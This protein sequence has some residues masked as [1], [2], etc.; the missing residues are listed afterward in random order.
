[1]LPWA[2]KPWRNAGCGA[3]RKYTATVRA[4][5]L[6][7]GLMRTTVAAS[8]VSRPSTRKVA[9]APTRTAT[10][11]C[12]ASAASSSSCE[13]STTSRIR[14]STATRSPGWLSR[15]AI[16]PSSGATRR[17]SF[18]D[19]R[20]RSAAA[21]A[22][23]RLARAPSA[24]DCAVSSAVGEMK[25]WPTSALLLASVRSATSS[26]AR[27]ERV[28]CSACCSR[29]WYSLVSICPSTCPARTLS[30]SRTVR[31]WSSP[32]T[33]A[34]T[35]A[36]RT[37]LTEPVTATERVKVWGRTLT[38]SSG[39]SSSAAVVGAVVGVSAARPRATSTSVTSTTSAAAIRT[40]RLFMRSKAC[41]WRRPWPER[42]RQCSA[43]DRAAP[44]ARG[45]GS[46]DAGRCRIPPASGT[47]P[48]SACAR[49]A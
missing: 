6:A 29:N 23:A 49:T 21:W 47:R 18:T 17:A 10:T 44:A 36:L 15:C 37:A 32:A 24:L 5:A 14:V 35:N 16:W 31:A 22:A 26:W 27:A 25:P 7:D 41:G 39:S 4:P 33:L 46:G 20:A 13:R 34:L 30:P 2:N 45:R 8:G 40:R 42:L 9:G 19:L 38:T 28:C 12:G 11:S 48:A 3:R 43:A 1:M